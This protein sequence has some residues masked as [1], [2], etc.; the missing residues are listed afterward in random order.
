[1]ALIPAAYKATV[2]A[3]NLSGKFICFMVAVAA[4]IWRE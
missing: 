1:M 2:V 4:L 3:P